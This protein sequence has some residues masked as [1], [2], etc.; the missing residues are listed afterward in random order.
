MTNGANNTVTKSFS[1]IVMADAI[2]AAANIESAFYKVAINL[3]GMNAA[4]QVEAV[5]GGGEVDEK[6]INNTWQ[7]FLQHHV[8][9]GNMVWRGT[10]SEVER[11]RA[12]RGDAK[13]L[14]AREYVMKKAKGSRLVPGLERAKTVVK[15]LVKDMIAN[16]SA[17]ILHLAQMERDGLNGE[18]IAD[19]FEGFVRG[20]YPESFSGLVDYFAKAPSEKAQKTVLEKAIAAA[21][22]I[23][24]LQELAVF[25]RQMQER[26][27]TFTAD[28]AAAEAAFAEGEAEAE[29]EAKPELIKAAA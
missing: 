5:I 26:L 14:A 17:T 1:A 28:A 21:E 29:A 18:A 12:M 15:E 20:T 4:K 10:E 2:K 3:A 19:H 16:H 23:T 6:R 13:K 27:A 11:I 22:E 9:A 7:V 25:V 24:D 8:L